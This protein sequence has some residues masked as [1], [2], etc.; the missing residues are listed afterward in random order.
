MSNDQDVLHL[1]PAVSRLKARW[2]SEVAVTGGGEVL[3][4]H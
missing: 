3:R 4:D 1:I 2:T